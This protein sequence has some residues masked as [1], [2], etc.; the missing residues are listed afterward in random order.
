[1]AGEILLLGGLVFFCIPDNRKLVVFIL[2]V[3][4]LTFGFSVANSILPS[5]YSK[6]IHPLDVRDSV[7][8]FGALSSF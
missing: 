6:Y 8:I 1:V 2:G 5:L 3:G 7:K 4:L